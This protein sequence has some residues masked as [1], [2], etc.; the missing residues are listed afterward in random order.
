MMDIASDPSSF[1]PVRSEDH[2]V[3]PR[4]PSS[5]L[6]PFCDPLLCA[7][8]FPCFVPLYLQL[9]FFVRLRCHQLAASFKMIPL[10]SSL[11]KPTRASN[12]QLPSHRFIRGVPMA[13]RSFRSQSLLPLHHCIGPRGQKPPLFM[14]YYNNERTLFCT[15]AH[16]GHEHSHSIRRSLPTVAQVPS[17]HSLNCGIQRIPRTQL[18]RP[19]SS[20]PDY[21]PHTVIEY[22]LSD[23]TFLFLPPTSLPYLPLFPFCE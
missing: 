15:R 4:K 9:P 7:D 22:F 23:I 21:T 12:T 2:A 8:L 11:F 5:I 10:F 16:L 18:L 1:P 20:R 13:R 14:L 19:F 3:R 17:L 6:P